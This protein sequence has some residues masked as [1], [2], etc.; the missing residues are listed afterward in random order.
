MRDLA[1]QL[2]LPRAA[3]WFWSGARRLTGCRFSRTAGPASWPE[4]RPCRDYREPARGDKAAAS[5]RTPE[6]RSN[7]A[8]DCGGEVREG[9]GEKA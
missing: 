6:P 1:Q 4:S 8:L 7:T 5:R 2:N 9:L 3:P